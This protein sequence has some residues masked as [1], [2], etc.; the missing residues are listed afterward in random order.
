MIHVRD[1][2]YT[3]LVPKFRAARSSAW[4]LNQII[5]HDL[6]PGL[7]P[8][9]TLLVNEAGIPEDGGIGVPPQCSPLISWRT[10]E[11]GRNNR[12]RTYMGTYTV[13]SVDYSNVG[14]PAFSA[15]Q[16]F[17]DAMMDLYTGTIGVDVPRFVIFSR[18]QDGVQ[19]DPPFYSPVT[20][21]FF[22]G[23]WASVHRRLI[24]DW[25]T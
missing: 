24:W 15:V 12:G 3:N 25:R 1:S 19:V 17:A 2:F 6:W 21:Y 14:D 22:Q 11:T 9:I 18:W 20:D 13:E 23:R 10:G 4:L 5:A 16:D 8:D 7:E